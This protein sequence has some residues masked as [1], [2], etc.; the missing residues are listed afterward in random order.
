MKRTDD[1]NL[2]AAAGRVELV[3]PASAR[4]GGFGCRFEPCAGSLDPLYARL[5]I[6]EQGGTRVVW[7]SCDLLG[8]STAQDKAFRDRI[9]ALTSVPADHVLISCTHTHSA[10][11]GTPMRGPSGAIDERWLREGVFDR[12]AA[13]A[14][15]LISDL[16]PVSEIEAGTQL[17]SGLG[18]NRQD[19]SCPIDERVHSAT[20]LDADRRVIASVINYA[21]HPVVIGETNLKSSADFPGYVSST[22]ERQL[23]GTAL[24]I[25][26]SCGDVDPVSYRDIGRHAGN[27]Q[28]I[29]TIGR[30]IAHGAL[31]SLKPKAGAN[32]GLS[33][34]S[35]QVEISLDEPESEAVLRRMRDEF[36]R[37]AGPVDPLPREPAARGAMFQL[38]WADEL[39]A[40]FKQNRVPKS[41]KAT[42][43][44][45][46]VGPIEMI[47]FPF[48]IYSAI[49]LEV[50]R[51]LAHRF[52]IIA[53][54][55]GGLIG[56][57]T[58]T[59]A[60]QQGGYGAALSH[61]YFPEL[62]TA[63]S[64]GADEKLVAASVELLKS[65]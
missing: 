28:M 12:V 16:R 5:L 19:A 33:I 29:A 52:V 27:S 65:N 35:T 17:V 3:P 1:S 57:V 14:A 55:T 41:L 44:A 36:A 46:R 2:L 10:P 45:L 13:V 58:T 63:I 39:L 8:F 7:V 54:Y 11:N 42:I 4:L 15:G 43:T 61:R 30:T 51:Q 20:F 18:Y 24:F 49:G 21:L 40:A 62:L 48:E 37:Q 53:A 23:G 31:E 25:N 50:R 38:A 34:R 59:L 26:G 6:F 47:T 9:S 64:A 56:Y 60:K 22:I 32:L